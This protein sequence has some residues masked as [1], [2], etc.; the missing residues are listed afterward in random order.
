MASTPQSSPSRSK[1]QSP[2]SQA[3]ASAPKSST[4]SPSPPKGES[5]SS[6]ASKSSSLSPPPPRKSASASSSSKDGKKKSSSSSSSDHTSAVITGVVLGVVG[7]ALLLSIVACVCC[8]QEEEET[9][10]AAKAASLPPAGMA[11]RRREP[12]VAITGLDGGAPERRDVLVRPPTALPSLHLHPTWALG[13][14]KS[15]FSYEELAAATSGFSSAN[16]LGQG[17]FGYVYKGV[18]AGSGK[19]VAVKQLKSGSGQGEREFQAEVE[20]ISR[21]HHRHLVSLVG[22]CIAGNQRMLVYEFVANNTLE[23]HL[24]WWRTSGLAKLTTDTNTHVSTR[25]MGTFGYLAPEYA[26][27]REAHGQVGRLLLRRHAAGAAHGGAAPSTPPTTWRIASWTGRARCWTP[28]LAGETGFAELVDPRLGGEYSAVEM[29]RLAACAAAS[30]RHSAKRRPKMSQIVR[31]LEGDAS[32]EDLHQDGVK[33][34]A[35][36][37]L[38]RR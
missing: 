34:G 21:V 17:G 31:A 9:N 14:S 7:F 36:R 28:R 3:S 22:Y 5:T 8:A 12:A 6:P 4:N 10:M 35:E 2:P 1:Q 13:F 29:E 20:I 18:L 19:E 11:P 37:A 30:T 27:Q 15:S 33:P 38:L 32:L 25:V 16:M 26:S 23:H 24:P